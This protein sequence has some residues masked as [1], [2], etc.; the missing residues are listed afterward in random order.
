[1]T[2]TNADGSAEDEETE[3]LNQRKAKRKMTLDSKKLEKDDSKSKKKRVLVEV[4]HDGA[5]ERQ[6]AVL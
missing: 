6:T 2:S 3:A 5:D 4:E 1:M